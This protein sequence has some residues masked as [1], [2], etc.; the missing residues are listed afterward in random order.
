MTYSFR[1]RPSILAGST[2][3]EPQGERKNNFT[4]KG[5]HSSIP[6]RSEKT[7]TKT[8]HDESTKPNRK[9][10]GRAAAFEVHVFILPPKTEFATKNAKSTKRDRKFSCLCVL[11]VLCGPS[12]DF[13][14]SRFL[15]LSLFRVFV[16]L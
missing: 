10:A 4:R 16:I 9:A 7:I 1:A 5:N 6:P 8:R 12:L 2:L 11:C 14:G 3:R 15:V 13:R